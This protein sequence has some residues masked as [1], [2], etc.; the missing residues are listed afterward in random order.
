MLQENKL[1][2]ICILIPIE[3]ENNVYMYIE[4]YVERG[5]ERLERQCLFPKEMEVFHILIILI[6]LPTFLL[7]FHLDKLFTYATSRRL[8]SN[9][10]S[11]G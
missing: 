5:R 6:C 4:M 10:P 8:K 9:V 1:K 2:L 7:H 3:W 11:T